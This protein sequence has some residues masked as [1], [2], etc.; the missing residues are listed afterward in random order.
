MRGMSWPTE[1]Q[2]VSQEG[3]YLRKKGFQVTA[4]VLE[5]PSL[6]ESV[7]VFQY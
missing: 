4:K 6:A 5:E 3:K 1:Q 7:H 2:I